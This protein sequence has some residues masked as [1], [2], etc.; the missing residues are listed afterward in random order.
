MH[1]IEDADNVGMTPRW[2]KNTEFH[3]TNLDNEE[4]RRP[5]TVIEELRQLV[6]EN[7]R[8]T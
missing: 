8:K 3:N 4:H 7:Q 1:F 6:E 2:L 5:N